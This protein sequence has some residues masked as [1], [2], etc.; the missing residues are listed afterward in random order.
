LVFTRYPNG[1]DVP[2]PVILGGNEFAGYGFTLSTASESN[3]CG[4]AKPAILPPH[5][6]GG[7]DFFA[8]STA[9]DVSTTPVTC[10]TVLIRITF[11]NPVSQIS[12]QFTG[13]QVAY[14][15][16]V[17]DQSGARVGSASQNGTLGGISTVTCAGLPAPS[18][19][20]LSASQ[21]AHSA[22]SKSNFSNRF[23]CIF[24]RRML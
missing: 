6:I 23:R 2:A 19:V 22:S 17:Y 12:I 18:R 9:T 10:N 1:P 3:Y 15:L 13:A 20:P 8:L 24:G 14:V 21:P 7:D 16:S 5:S 4:N 11:T